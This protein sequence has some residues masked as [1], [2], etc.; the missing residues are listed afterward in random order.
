MKRSK[1]I[2]FSTDAMLLK[3]PLAISI[4]TVDNHI[5]YIILL[6]NFKMYYIVY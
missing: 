5:L 1:I 6:F 3:L 2:F 4:A